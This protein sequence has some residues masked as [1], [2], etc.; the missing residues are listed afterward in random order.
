MNNAPQR[1]RLIRLREVIALTG[2]SRST[3]LRLEA[4]ARFPLHVRVGEAS[5]AW[6]EDEVLQ[7]IA[8]RIAARD[9]QR[10]VA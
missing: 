7:W 8:E 6:V 4:Q 10:A 9:A 5:I 1:N 3:I 2:L